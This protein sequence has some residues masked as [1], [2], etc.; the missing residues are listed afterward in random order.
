MWHFDCPFKCTFKDI[1]CRIHGIK[2]VLPPTNTHASVPICPLNIFTL[3]YRTLS[4]ASLCSGN[5]LRCQTETR[6]TSPPLTSTEAM[7]TLGFWQKNLQLWFILQALPR[8][9]YMITSDF[10]YLRLNT[11]H[12][13]TSELEWLQ[14]VLNFLLTDDWKCCLSWVILKCKVPGIITD[15]DAIRLQVSYTFN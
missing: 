9:S 1:L 7:A 2:P 14:R 11:E 12:L 5:N 6:Q 10:M 15:F 3:D 4:L 8:L 13:I